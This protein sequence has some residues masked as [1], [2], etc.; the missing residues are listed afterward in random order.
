MITIIIISIII[1][2]LIIT[3]IIISIGVFDSADSAN[4]KAFSFIASNDETNVYAYTTSNE[5]K[6]KLS[7]DK[8]T[9]VVLK[10]FDEGNI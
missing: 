8:D 2:I 7:I 1:I 9:V 5:V 6:R 3:I 10:T 4:Y